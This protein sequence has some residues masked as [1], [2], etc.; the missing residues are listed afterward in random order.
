MT[1]S[2]LLNL[3]NLKKNEIKNAD[4]IVLSI[5]V[6]N[7]LN[8]VIQK[9]CNELDLNI[10]SLKNYDETTFDLI[11]GKYLIL[12]HDVAQ[13]YLRVVLAWSYIDIG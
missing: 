7:V 12:V 8:T 6:N 9:L 2:D 5:G 4:L 11:I 13:V 3:I 10:E 1:S